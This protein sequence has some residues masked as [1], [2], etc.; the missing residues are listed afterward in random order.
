MQQ[1]HMG[2]QEWEEPE[3][4]EIGGYFWGFQTL[5]QEEPPSL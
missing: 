1:Q 5:M 3:S 4:G 2:W